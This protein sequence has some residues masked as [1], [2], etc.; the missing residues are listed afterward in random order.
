MKKRLAVHNLDG[1]QVVEEEHP[2]EVPAGLHLGRLEVLRHR[3]LVAVDGVVVYVRVDGRND[4]EE[5]LEHA[6]LPLGHGVRR[7]VDSDAVEGV[8]DPREVAAEAQFVDGVA[9]VK[10]VGVEWQEV[11][12]VHVPLLERLA[13]REVDVPSN[14]V[15]RDGPPYVA[16][17][18]CLLLDPVVEALLVALDDPVEADQGPTLPAV[19]LADL[20]AGV[21][22]LVVLVIGAVAAPA[23]GR[24]G[25]RRVDL[26]GG[27]D[28][29]PLP[30]VEG[31]ALGGKPAPV[32]V[33]V[34]VK[35][36]I[37]AYVHG[38]QAHPRAGHPRES[39]VHIYVELLAPRDIHRELMTCLH[40]EEETQL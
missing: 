32:H 6:G 28:V 13:G 39:H 16:A 26:F 21:A 33:V 27:P 7:L 25:C 4:L 1:R 31:E 38:V 15:H 2:R 17:L 10:L 24:V 8:D 19:C 18:A 22:A 9:Q 30:V 37:P 11:V 20:V 40:F 3:E 29:V 34:H 5:V 14:L 36:E 12:H 23:L 35:V